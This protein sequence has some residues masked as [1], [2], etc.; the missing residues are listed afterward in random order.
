MIVHYIWIGSNPIPQEYLFNL[1]KC[2]QLNPQY[3][4][5][6]WGNDESLQLIADNNHIEYWSSLTFICKLN[7]IKYLILDKFGGIYTDFDIEWNKSFQEIFNITS[8]SSGILLSIN[9]YSLMFIDNKPTYILDDPF[10]YSNPGIF[11]SCLKYC[12]SR[13]KLT[14]DGNLYQ[15]TGESKPHKSEPIGPFGLTEWIYYNNININS[16][17][18]SGNLDQLIGKFGFHRQKGD[19]DKFN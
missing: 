10:I 18:Q 3:E 19:W 5:K 16:F 9:N 2:K 8:I 12:M 15:E 11:D 14:Q 6:I 17:T 7:F 4:F 13:T 1:E